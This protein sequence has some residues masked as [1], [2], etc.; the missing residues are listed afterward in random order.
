METYVIHGHLKGLLRYYTSQSIK[1]EGWGGGA[2]QAFI[3]SKV[4]PPALLKT[5]LLFPPP[6]F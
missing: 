5:Q 2:G 3:S 6:I 4:F 1:M